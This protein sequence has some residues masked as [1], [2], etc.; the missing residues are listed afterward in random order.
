MNQ[1]FNTLCYYYWR[2]TL[3]V[4]CFRRPTG[5][6]QP[7]VCKPCVTGQYYCHCLTK[8]L[9]GCQAYKC[10]FL[11]FPLS[12]D[13]MTN[14]TGVILTEEPCPKLALETLEELDWCLDQLETLQTRHSVSEM[15]SNKVRWPLTP[16]MCSP[17]TWVLVFH[18]W[19]PVCVSLTF[20]LIF[21]IW[22]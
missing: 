14:Y 5:S 4:S 8:H 2:H 7:P 22:S 18:S 12:P 17:V 9:G 16:S 15:A 10:P 6:N 19:R 21:V 13:L 1:S 3:Y 11:L 20:S